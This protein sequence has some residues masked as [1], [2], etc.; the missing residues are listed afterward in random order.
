MHS[1]LMKPILPMVK[2]LDAVCTVKLA[3]YHC[4]R[5]VL[6]DL[7]IQKASRLIIPNIPY[8]HLRGILNRG[9][10]RVQGEGTYSMDPMSCV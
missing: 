9:A 3:Y 2:F 4:S 8:L 1:Y 10:A 5:C 7:V 6:V